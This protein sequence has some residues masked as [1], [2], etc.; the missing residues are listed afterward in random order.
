MNKVYYI[1]QRL[2]GQYRTMEYDVKHYTLLMGWSP[3][4]DKAKRYDRYGDAIMHIK[5]L[6]KPGDYWIRAI[7]VE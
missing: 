1:I 6:P 7:I 3:E 4:I 2:D 5:S